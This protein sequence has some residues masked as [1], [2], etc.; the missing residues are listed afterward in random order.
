MR[1][2][3]SS[4]G[5]NLP[6][7]QRPRFNPWVGNVPWRREWQPT[8]VFLPAEFHGQRSLAGYSPWVAES[9]TRLSDTHTH[10]HTHTHTFISVYL[11]RKVLCKSCVSQKTKCKLG[12]DEPGG[13][14]MWGKGIPT[15]LG[16][17]WSRATRAREL[18]IG[19]HRGKAI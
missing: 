5:K 8:P 12:S 14:C 18:G 19:Q 15:G 11:F 2:P 4:N 16:P 3:G 10:T 13:A 17:G 7:M 1:F 6:A 9:Q